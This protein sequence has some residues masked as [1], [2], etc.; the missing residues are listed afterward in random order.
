LEAGDRVKRALLEE[1]ADNSE[2]DYTDEDIMTPFAGDAISSIMHGMKPFRNIVKRYWTEEE[3]TYN[4][5]YVNL[6]QEV[7]RTGWLIRG[8]NIL[9]SF[10]HFIL[11]YRLKTGRE[12]LLSLIIALMCNAFTAGR[13]CSIQLWLRDPGPMKRIWLSLSR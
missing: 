8:K 12:S 11:D 1:D 13:K 7:E 5:T 4:L 9:R 3:V 10:K 6:G 2:S